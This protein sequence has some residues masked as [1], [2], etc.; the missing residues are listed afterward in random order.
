[1]AHNIDSLVVNGSDLY[2]N[3]LLHQGITATVF[4]SWWN[5]KQVNVW[6]MLIGVKSWSWIVLWCCWT[7]RKSTALS[8]D[9]NTSVHT[10]FSVSDA[11][12][13]TSGE[14]TTAFIHSDNYYYVFDSHARN[15]NG[16]PFA[17][18]AAVLLKF[19]NIDQLLQYIVIHY[20]ANAFNFPCRN[21]YWYLKCSSISQLLS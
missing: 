13:Y 9:I 11:L 6:N 12:L 14:Q 17:N 10:A 19:D 18:G 5:S 4:G 8:V 1:M 15:Q 2:D 7:R 3:I 16:F 21:I 20:T